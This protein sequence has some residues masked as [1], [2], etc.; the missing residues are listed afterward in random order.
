MAITQLGPA[1]VFRTC[2]PADLDFETTAELDEL[3]EII[4]QPRAV[5]AVRFGIGI[6]GKG[7]NLFAHGDAG[8]G[9]RSLVQRY[10][11]QQATAEAVP[12]DLCYINNFQQT[13]KPHRLSLPAGRGIEL[14]RDME[15]FIEDLHGAIP[16][17]FESSEYRTRAQAI[18]EEINEQQAQALKKIHDSAEEKSITLMQTPTGFTLAPVHKGEVL[19]YE[20][21]QRLPEKERKRI[22]ADTEELQQQLSKALHEAPRLQKEGRDRIGR[23]NR[24]MAGATVSHLV[25]VLQ[26]KYAELPAVGAFLDEVQ[27]DVIT[28][29]R[30]FLHEHED[31]H[32][33]AGLLGIGGAGQSDGMSWENRYRVNILVSHAGA[34]GAPVIYADYPSYNNLIGRVEHQAQ[35][36]ALL[37]D[38]TMIRAGELHRANGGYLILDVLKVLMQPF[39]WEGLKR[40]LQA[41]E[42]RIESPA[43][44]TSLIST[45]SVEPEAIPLD[46]K[47]ILLGERHLYYLLSTVDPEF[48][49]L[50]KV[51]VDFSD[52]MQRDGDSQQA[53][54][55]LIAG[56]IRQEKLR[57]FDRSAV[58]RLIENSSRKMSDSEKLDTHMSSL[59]DLLRE[60]DYFA[61]RREADI[62]SRPDVQQ[63]IEGQ[64]YRADRIRELIQEEIR[65]GTLF[66]DT[67][68]SCAGRVN[69][70]SVTELGN[71]MFGR[72]V[73]IT[74]RVRV[75]DNQVIDIEREVE[76]GGPIHSKGVFILSAFIGARFLPDM[77]LALS[78]SLV[79]EQSYGEVEGDSASSAELYALLSALSGLPVKQSL[80]VTGSV[81]QHGDIQPIGGVNEK[82]EG[83]FDTCR[84]AGLNG[85]QGVVIPASNVRH[86]MLREDVQLAVDAGEFTIYAI[87]HVDD[88]IELLTGVVAGERDESG[89]FPEGTVNRLVEETLLR[90]AESMRAFVGKSRDVDAQERPA[91]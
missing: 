9:K 51:A 24:E 40:T 14:Q 43:Q 15:Q 53:Y 62:V 60:A 13:H 64:V 23:L 61:A 79:F 46:I 25:G 4:G 42:I 5:E 58:A 66:I 91:T 37:T 47:V 39:A 32:K 86:L 19:G 54:A 2:N 35:L 85:K 1:D 7:Y 27:E 12:P 74:A 71:F 89:Q 81:N 18:E 36:G 11:E 31:G 3:E 16:A 34:S 80:A 78:A 65:R 68:G 63:A 70:L 29:F 21:F 28:N 76:L 88:G 52:R 49:E 82:I 87:E 8:S 20:E 38:F 33:A 59:V 41:G 6:R 48:G 73:R 83:F 50:F 77:P 69:G 75:G 57:Q 55:R 84:Q 72:P 30:H 22:E 56:M 44:L 67:Q 45:V 90:Y 10:A 26:R 17:V